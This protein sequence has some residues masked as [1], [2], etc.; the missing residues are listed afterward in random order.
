MV[1]ARFEIL[2]A[3][4]V[5]ANGKIDERAL[6]PPHD[7]NSRHV[8]PRT[9]AEHTIAGIFNT[10]LGRQ[11]VSVYDDFFELGG[12]SL[13]ATQLVS[14]IRSTLGVEL[15]V[16]AIF[17]TPTIAVLAAALA[18][19]TTTDQSATRDIAC[20]PRHR[21]RARLAPDGELVLDQS[22]RDLLHLDD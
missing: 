5:T 21:Y 11:R 18:K 22:L 2:E 12:H 1:P 13:L 6:P 19:T 4:P 8:A 10:L 16:S 15:S 17:G 9:P 7:D 3:L 20:A 14:R